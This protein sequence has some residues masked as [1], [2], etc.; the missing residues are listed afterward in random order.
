MKQS[1]RRMR[2]VH[3]W[4]QRVADKWVTRGHRFDPFTDLNGDECARRI[5]AS[6]N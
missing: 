6:I 2:A 3:A 4:R 1:K 5:V